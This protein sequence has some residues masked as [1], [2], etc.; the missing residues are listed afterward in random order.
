MIQMMD[1][2]NSVNDPLF[3][4]HHAAM[5]Q[6]WT[7]WQDQDPKRTLDFSTKRIEK[8]PFSADSSLDVGVFAPQRRARDVFDT[9]NTDGTG[10][11]CFKYEGLPIEKYL[12]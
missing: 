1:P 7:L 2:F 12:I 5:D 9:L 6:L 10:I 8:P 3:F 11:L 4:M